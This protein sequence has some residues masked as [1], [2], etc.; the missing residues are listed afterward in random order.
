MAESDLAAILSRVRRLTAE[1]DGASDAQLLGRFA[2][3]RDEAA[4]ELLLWRHARLVFGV[5]R[6]VLHDPHDAEDAFQATFLAL[7]RHAGRIAQREAVA[8]WLHQVASRV[9]LTA[10][11]QRARR[12][13]REELIG[14]AEHLSAAPEAEAPLENQELR[15]V[16]DQE[17]GRLPER[18]RVA[19]VL[20]YLEGKSVDEA[21][22]Q[23][24]CPRGTVASRLAR[25]RAR[26]RVRL[27]GRGL[28]VTAALAILTQA[29]AAPRPLALIPTLTAAALRYAAGGAAG[30][31]VLSPRIT[32]LTEEVLRAMF[33]HR[34]KTGIVILIAFLGILLAGGVAVGLHAHAG[35]GAEPPRTGEVAK[36]QAAAREE[37]AGDKPVAE[38]LHTVT[39]SRP[40]RREAAPYAAY[41]GQL[42]ARQAVE[43]RPAV[44]GFVQ[45]VC[46]K[47]GAEVK[48]GD[49][50]FELDSRASQLALDKA[51][52]ELALAEAKK[53]QSDADLKRARKLL[54]ARIARE[55]FDTITER[56]ATAEAEVKKAK[57]EV[58]R[59]RLELEAT[60]VTAPMSGQVGRPLVEPGTLVFRGQDRA[61]LLT[62]VTSLD[63]IGL[64]FDMDERSFLT[65]QR[66]LREKQVKG[67][68]SSLRMGL[69]GEKGSPHEGTLD[70]FEDRFSPQTGTVRV[71]GIFPNPG[72]LLLPGMRARV[73]MTLGPPRAV[74]E[75][76]EEAILSDQGMK[77]V[78]VV[79][80]RN[81]TERR[82]VTLGLTDNGMRI[83]E[84]GLGAEDWVV[85]AGLNGIHPGDSVEPRKKATP[86]R[87]EPSPDRGR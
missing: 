29:N 48:K 65:Y 39:V 72:Q 43:V 12:E 44:G 6:R 86:A 42:E 47:A 14:T 25:A 11:R 37:P 13:A 32:A 10:R 20:C 28:A 81:V 26:L 16:L 41:E 35:P 80:D 17:I 51:E 87:E 31:G 38:A 64:T 62:T 76:P 2:A 84:K 71:R 18:F 56:A 83:V 52:A 85:I 63:P 1:G 34:L 66:L 9:A 58:A 57:V 67:A 53:K 77:Y 40:L 61:T 15:C 30:D 73:R 19:V 27:A 59:A 70:S 75:V 5:C 23:L 36:A 49:V 74:L 45:K 69:A 50:L 68:G 24:G 54:E 7:A 3:N 4:F 22:L 8:G 78:L 46:F 55:E 33:L 79:N 21:A 60:K 82:A